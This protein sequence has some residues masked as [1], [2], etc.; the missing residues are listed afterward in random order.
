[1]NKRRLQLVLLSALI[2]VSCNLI[3]QSPGGIE[4]QSFWL[5]HRSS[6]GV[7]TSD[8]LN[9]NP[10][11]A[12]DK[13]DMN[14]ELPSSLNSL[15]RVTIFTVYFG[16]NTPSELPIWQLTGDLGDISLSTDHVASTN[17]R[18]KFD[19]KNGSAQTQP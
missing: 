4:G 12:I 1:M 7:A 17:G 14:I 6:N 3:A 18:L 15:R 9:F 8:F 19:F 2:S 13:G 10:A 16:I 5:K 11:I